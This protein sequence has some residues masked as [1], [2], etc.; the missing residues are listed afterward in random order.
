MGYISRMKKNNR[1]KNK[2][3]IYFVKNDNARGNILKYSKRR[4]KFKV[5]RPFAARGNERIL[6]GKNNGFQLTGH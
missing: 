2:L 1:C 4:T 3:K 6:E 5:N